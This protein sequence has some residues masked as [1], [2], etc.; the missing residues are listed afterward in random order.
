MDVA[1]VFGE[2]ATPGGIRIEQPG[3]PAPA[4]RPRVGSNDPAR[5]IQLLLERCPGRTIEELRA[6]L[7][8]G[9]K[10]QQMREAYG[11]VV[12]AVRAIRA[13]RLATPR[14]LAIG[15]D[16]GLRTIYRLASE[17]TGT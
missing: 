3:S 15:L 6:C 10:T 2:T 13:E 17:P 11:E 16:S 5:A 8:P 7:R 4:G 1:A 14:A 9:H 12:P